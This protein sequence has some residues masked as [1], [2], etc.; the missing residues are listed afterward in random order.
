VGGG[1]TL[2]RG[3]TEARRRKREAFK[4]DWPK[5]PNNWVVLRGALELKWETAARS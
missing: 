3:T 1:Y 5:K 2:F 4:T